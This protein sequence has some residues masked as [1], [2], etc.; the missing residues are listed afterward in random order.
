MGFSIF[1]VPRC[2]IHTLASFW[3]DGAHG[4][5]NT[6]RSSSSFKFLGSNTNGLEGGSSR[7]WARRPITSK[8]EG[9]N[10]FTQS[11]ER[12]KIRHEIVDETVS[13]STNLIIGKLELSESQRLQYCE[14]QERVAKDKELAKLV[15][16][17][18]FDS[19]TTGFSRTNDKIIELGFQ[20]LS[21]GVNSTFQTLVNPERIVPNPH[22][23]GITT[24]MV[25][26][27]DVPRYH[28]TAD[29]FF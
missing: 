23:H 25:N 22:I 15:T 28:L 3:R 24:H 9:K 19:E 14:V 8:S 21:G 11:S 5:G 27:P 1:Q 20:D 12:S 29:F 2:R 16:V 6:C 17:I 26:R 13:T 4:L 10:K 7:R 18:V